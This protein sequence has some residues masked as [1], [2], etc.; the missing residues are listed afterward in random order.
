MVIQLTK[1]AEQGKGVWCLYPLSG[2]GKD[3]VRVKVRPHTDA[4]YRKLR[5]MVG[6]PVL[7]VGPEA[8]AALQQMLESKADADKHATK[9]EQLEVALVDYYIEDWRGFVDDDFDLIN[10][11]AKEHKGR[12][13]QAWKMAMCEFVPGFKNWVLAEARGHF[14]A[15]AKKKPTSKAGSGTTRRRRKST[16]TTSARRSSKT[17]TRR[18][19]KN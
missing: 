1:A 17:G 12:T 15:D 3:E 9:L 6:L 10:I 2:G 18:P 8:L 19:K 7:E 5:V 13:R 11:K 16:A 14:I 4:T